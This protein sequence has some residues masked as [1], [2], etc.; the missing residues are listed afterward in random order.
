[1]N[2]KE[3]VLGKNNSRAR[4]RIS[5]GRIWPAGPHFANPHLLGRNK[6]LCKKE[7]ALRVLVV[8]KHNQKYKTERLYL[9]QNFSRLF[10]VPT[11]SKENQYYYGL[12][13][14]MAWPRQRTQY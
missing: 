1:M 6:H 8:K 12:N 10:R 5:V 3:T 7:V 11:N 13:L 14:G 2:Y 4:Q 9:E